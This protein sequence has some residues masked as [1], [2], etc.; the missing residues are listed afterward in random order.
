MFQS[1]NTLAA[2][3]IAAITVTALFTLGPPM[4][5][6]ADASDDGGRLGKRLA[7]TY[8]GEVFIEGGPVVLTFFVQ[9]H[10]NGTWIST[11]DLDA[12][13]LSASPLLG[14]WVATGR[15]TAKVRGLFF[16]FD[17]AECHS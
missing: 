7:G 2:R 1:K 14:A 15:R 17:E 9:F 6:I 8:A 11:D 10:A 16:E 12:G 5:A 4:T 3:V 13:E